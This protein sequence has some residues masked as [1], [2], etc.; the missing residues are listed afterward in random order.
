VPEVLHLKL[1]QETIL[2]FCI[3]LS[4]KEEGGGGGGGG[5]GGEDDDPA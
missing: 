2:Q 1:G 4:Q 3:F 5:G